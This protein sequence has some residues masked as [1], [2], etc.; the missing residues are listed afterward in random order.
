MTLW[1]TPRINVNFNNAVKKLGGFWNGEAWEVS[2]D[3]D[4]KLQK[5][6]DKY[7]GCEKVPLKITAKERISESRGPVLFAGFVVTRAFGRDSGAKLGT[8]VALISGD[9]DSGGS[10]K[11][12]LT[13]VDEKSVFV[14]SDFPKSLIEKIRTE[15]WNY[16]IFSGEDDDEED[17]EEF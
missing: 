14:I 2:S 9:H 16:E 11:N 10:V 4:A 7:F 13:I 5:L 15:K 3:F 12:W 17:I 6:H 8:G 1:K